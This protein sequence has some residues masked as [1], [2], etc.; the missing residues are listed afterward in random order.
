MICRECKDI[1]T[2]YIC[3]ECKNEVTN[4]CLECHNEIWHGKIEHNT[5]M[6]VHGGSPFSSPFYEDDA[7]YYPG[8][9]DKF[10]DA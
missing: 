8:I 5:G 10:R 1:F 7:Q 4:L 2:P 3:D 6:P 9:C